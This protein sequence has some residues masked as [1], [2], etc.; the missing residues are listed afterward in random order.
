MISPLTPEGIKLRYSTN[1]IED[2]AKVYFR[3]I[4]DPGSNEKF[5]AVDSIQW[6]FAT[7]RFFYGFKQ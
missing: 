7:S 6:T 2:I 4:F 3:I 1:V 5:I